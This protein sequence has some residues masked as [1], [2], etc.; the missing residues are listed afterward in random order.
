MSAELNPQTFEYHIVNV[1]A[2]S[3]WGGNPL[4]IVPNADALDT[5][6]MQLIARQFNLSETVF[7]CQSDEHAAHLR[8]FTPEHELPFAGHPTIGSA[9]FLHQHLNL[10]DQFTVQTNA[11]TVAIEHKEG[12]YQLTVSGYEAK[13]CAFSVLHL[14]DALN[15]QPNDI[16]EPAT[17]MNAGS[18]QL[19]VPVASTDAVNRVRP[20]LSA[21]LDQSVD[22]AHL[23]VY[24]WH[25]ENNQVTSRYFFNVDNAVIE[26]PGTGGACANL[27][28]YAHSRG[29][30]PLSWHIT[31]AAAIE[32]PNHLYLNVKQTGEISIGGRVMP[33]STGVFSLPN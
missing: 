17:W 20:N 15:L 6:T 9:W 16:V 13:N 30:T 27:G 25:E 23:Y 18:W 33:F 4:A 32:R 3:A 26:D 2:Q 21:L 31:Q 5:R 24:I 22:A 14:A 8:I 12:L 10:P 28:A 29:R 11:K 7:L 19:L 1:F